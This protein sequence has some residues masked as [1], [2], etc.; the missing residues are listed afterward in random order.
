M[1]HPILS[2]SSKILIVFFSFLKTLLENSWFTT[3]CL[4]CWFQV[5][6]KVNQLCMCVCVCVCAQSISCIWLFVTP[7]TVGYKAPL[8][9]EFSRQKYWSGLSFPTWDLPNWRI[10]AMFLGSPTLPGRFFPLWHL[11]SLLYIYICPLFFR[12]FFLYRPLQTN[13]LSFLCYT[14]NL[15]QLLKIFLIYC[16]CPFRFCLSYLKE[17]FWHY[18]ILLLL[19]ISEVLLEFY[20]EYL[21][22]AR[23]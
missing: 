16:K 14:V 2:L 11:E 22:L 4:L 5:Y 8:S 13:E 6:N 1:S 15:F 19:Y 23:T 7:W 10:K 20:V 21:C 12:F 18:V 3:V 9:M 17:T